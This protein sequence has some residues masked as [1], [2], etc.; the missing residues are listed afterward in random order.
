DKPLLEALL[1]VGDERKIMFGLLNS[2]IDPSKKKKKVDDGIVHDLSPAAQV[3]VELFNRSRKDKKAIAYDL[4]RPATAPEGWLPEFSTV[5]TLQE[6]TIGW[7]DSRKSP[8]GKTPPAVHIHHKFIVVDAETEHPVI[9]VGSANMSNNSLHKNDE[10]LLEITNSP[11][12]GQIYLAEFMRL[13]E[14][15]RARALWEQ[16]HPASKGK[17][18]TEATAAG[19]AKTFTLK[20]TRDAWVRGAYKPGT[21]EYNIR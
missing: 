10:N 21:N 6:K 14:H 4:F 15:Y 1:R 16:S 11:R 7:S 20:A 12:L 18:K 19:R 8:G 9:Y 3:Q 17:T 13:Y 2:I 5:G